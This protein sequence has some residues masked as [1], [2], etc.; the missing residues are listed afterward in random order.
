MGLRDDGPVIRLNRFALLIVVR[1]Q[2]DDLDF[3]GGINAERQAEIMDDVAPFAVPLIVP[4]YRFVFSSADE[5]ATRRSVAVSAHSPRTR[6]RNSVHDFK[7]MAFA[8]G[9]QNAN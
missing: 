3:L 1:P 6:R 4:T 5:A 9:L 7:R 8:L 2:G